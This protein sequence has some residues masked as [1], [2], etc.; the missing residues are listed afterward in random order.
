MFTITTQGSFISDGLSRVIQ[1]PEG[2][3]WF[4]VENW[5]NIVAQT[6]DAGNEWYWYRGG[7]NGPQMP[8]NDGFIQGFVGGAGAYGM[9]NIRSLAPAGGVTGGFTLINSTTQLPAL[10]GTTVTSAPGNPIIVQTNAVGAGQAGTTALNVNQTVI[11]MNYN[12]VLGATPSLMGI[13]FTVSAIGDAT[14]FSLPANGLASFAG[15]PAIGIVNFSIVSY[16]VDPLFYP[17]RRTVIN[18]TNAV[19]PQVTTSVVHNYTV[20]QTIRMKVPKVCGMIQMNDLEG[21]VATVVD[22]YNFTL[23]DTENFHVDSTGFTPFVWPALADYPYQL[24]ECLPVGEAC[25]VP[26]ST[27]YLDA[28]V[29]QGYYGMILG[30]GTNAASSLLAPAG[31]NGDVIY[32]QAGKVTNL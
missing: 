2:I 31:T 12:G 29:N 4:K 20:G 15:L 24:A 16:S 21:V 28:T 32:W 23:G 9:T 26:Y 30:A 3:D 22:P 1:V 7:A 10:Q 17:T 5:T 6:A 25:A 8:V 14:H 18:I 19:N 11:R 27:S 13:D